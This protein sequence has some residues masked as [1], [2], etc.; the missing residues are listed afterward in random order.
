MKRPAPTATGG[1]LRIVQNRQNGL[2]SCPGH[3]SDFVRCDPAHRLHQRGLPLRLGAEPAIPMLR[4]LKTECQSTQMCDFAHEF[5]RRLWIAILQFAI[6]RTHAAHRAQ[7]AVSAFCGTSCLL[8]ANA[9]WKMIPALAYVDRADLVGVL[10][11][12]DAGA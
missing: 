5:N 6:R 1:A 8:L 9:Q 11:R 7:T 10:V 12:D 4:N 2:R 3:G